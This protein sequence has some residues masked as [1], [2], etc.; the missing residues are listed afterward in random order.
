MKRIVASVG[1]VAL[2]AASVHAQA[3]G[4][5]PKWWSASA[6]LRGFYDD[7]LNT[8]PDGSPKVHTFGYQVR[9]ALGIS[10]GNDQTSFSANYAYSFL[11]YDKRPAGNTEK[12][13]QDHIFDLALNH[14]F[15]ERYQLHVGDRF[16]VGQQPDALRTDNFTHT[17]FRLSGDNIV[18]A[19][20]I[21]LDDQLTPVFGLQLGY[22]NDLY[23][24][25]DHNTT[26]GPSTAGLLNR[27]ENY[28][29]IDGR[30]RVMPDT[31]AL[32]GYQYGDV[33]YTANEFLG[34]DSLG[35]PQTSDVRNNRSHTGYVG[36]EHEFNPQFTGAVKVG[37][38]YY[39]YYN[40]PTTTGS[41]GPYALAT[42]SY[43]YAPESYVRIG[44]QES[45]IAS[46]LVGNTTTEFIHDQ[47]TSV[48][49]ATL[50]HRIV[51]N[52]FAGLNGTFQNG[53]FNG[54]GPTFDGKSER[55]YQVGVDLEYQFTP[56]FSADAGYDY[57][58][59]DSDIAGRN[60]QRNKVYM[61]VT[62]S[63]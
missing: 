5:A 35:N 47:E 10:I 33:D 36:L 50:R 45:R 39:D 3:T 7:N 62:A 26:F 53:T 6:T 24:Y 57:D 49:F 21:T 12:Y 63:Y 60:Y 11:Y 25:A 37:A 52:L 58:R 18:N 20:T 8:S 51:P 29:H 48:F 46:T 41:F 42:L 13:D 9:P 34:I 2:G 27:I 30:W 54:G 61:G 19:G 28:A 59:L 23:D 4:P 31:V 56:H 44:F 15:S 22:D 43:T 40:D 55:F 38:S 32:L 16:V 1:L 17:V 14:S